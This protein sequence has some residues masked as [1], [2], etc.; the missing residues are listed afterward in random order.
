M[1][2]TKKYLSSRNWGYQ[3]LQRRKCS[4]KISFFP[5][6]TSIFKVAPYF[7]AFQFC[8]NLSMVLSWTWMS[9]VRILEQID[10]VQVVMYCIGLH[11]FNDDTCPSGHIRHPSQIGISYS[12]LCSIN[13]LQSLVVLLSCWG[14]FSFRILSVGDWF[15]WGVVLEIWPFIISDK[16]IQILSETLIR[17][18]EGIWIISSGMKG[19]KTNWPLNFWLHNLIYTYLESS[20]PLNDWRYLSPVQCQAIITWIETMLTDLWTWL[21]PSNYLNQ[22]WNIF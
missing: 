1:D 9:V 21:A 13:G 20:S 4:S 14:W 7:N 10:H 15:K 5:Q 12:C 19:H 8:R 22:C 2:V 18:S 6:Q 3:I 16:I 11:S 17:V